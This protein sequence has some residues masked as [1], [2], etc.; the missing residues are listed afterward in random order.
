[1]I[2]SSS[3]T[4]G[5]MITSEPV[6][7]VFPKR[8]NAIEFITIDSGS[9]IGLAAFSSSNVPVRMCMFT[10]KLGDWEFRLRF[11]NWKFDEYLKTIE[12]IPNHTPAYIEKPAFQESD[13]GLVC[14]RGGSLYKLI[15]AFVLQAY[16][17]ERNNFK[18]IEV[19]VVKW[20]G[21]L[22]K[23]K[24]DFRIKKLID[25]EYAEHI[26]DA[27]GIGLWVKGLFGKGMK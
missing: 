23:K 13:K 27:V 2:V 24:V 26:S 10:G 4:D 21:Q 22:D 3:L 8:E 20:K 11:A 1:M 6:K 9:N 5:I 12:H 15:K 18:V 14:A 16:I 19:P 7:L 25:H 17:L